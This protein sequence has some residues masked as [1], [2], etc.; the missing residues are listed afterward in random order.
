MGHMDFPLYIPNHLYSNNKPIINL[1]NIGDV[2]YHRCSYEKLGNPY[3]S[4]TITDLSHN[5]GVNNGNVISSKEDV[6]YSI[7]RDELIQK[8]DQAICELEIVS[9]NVNSNYHKFFYQIKNE[10]EIKG[11]IKLLHQ[12]V[13]FMYPHCIFRV[14]IDDVIVTYDNYKASLKKVNEIRT[15][16][17]HEFTKMIRRQEISQE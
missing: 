15:A 3:L 8:Y 11:E 7:K 6:L 17:K 5:I 4:I 16:I 10:K 9:L 12:P 2:L 13:P 14:W 1:F